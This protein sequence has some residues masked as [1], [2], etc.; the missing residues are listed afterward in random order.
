MTGCLILGVVVVNIGLLGVFIRFEIVLLITC[1]SLMLIV[2]LELFQL[3][4]RVLEA[5]EKG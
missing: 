2:T 5:L 3:L 4:S 1:D